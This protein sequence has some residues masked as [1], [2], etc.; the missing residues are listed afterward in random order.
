MR[1]VMLVGIAAA[2]LAGVAGC[3]KKAADGAA[4]TGEAKPA[5]AAAPAAMSMPQRKPG[6]WAQTIQ[7]AGM[8]QTTKICLDADTDAK[9]ALWGQQMKDQ[10]NCK[11]NSVGPTPGGVAFE[12]E[13]DMG[14]SGH[15]VAK[16]TA[17]GDFSSKYV[18]KV[19]STTTGASMPQ[20]N[21]TH[22][23][24]ITA[25]YKGACPA[26]MKGG[27]ISM[28]IPGMAGHTMNLEEMQKMAGK[29]RA[30]AGK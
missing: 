3:Q 6:L 22:E 7:V 13:C 26:G 4:A 21:G 28:D 2:A 27:D 18:V 1:R 16:G 29:A 23:M 15:I 20:A 12:S 8:N 10:T 19:S 25:E 30:Q 11:Q 5:A 14:E 17:I 9:M 24:Q